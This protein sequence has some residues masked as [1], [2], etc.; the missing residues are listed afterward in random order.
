MVGILIHI[1][2][3]VMMQG[4]ENKSKEARIGLKDWL[5]MKQMKERKCYFKKLVFF[6]GKCISV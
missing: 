5:A 6:V 1:P 4:S 3:N 2:L